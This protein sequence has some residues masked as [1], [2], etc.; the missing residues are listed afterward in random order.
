MLFRKGYLRVVIAT[1]TLALGINMPC[2]TV[3][4]SGDSVFLTALNYR[5]AAGRA[6]RRGF[7]LLGNVVFQGV[8]YDKV[9]RLLS[10]R[11]PD[12]NGHFPVTTT[13]VLRLF[14]LLHES[15]SPPY[16]IRA[17]DSLLSQPRLYL[18]GPS[19]RDQVLHHLRFSIEYLR[20]QRLLSAGGAPINFAGLVSHLYF[21]ENSSFALNVLLEGGYFHE[22]CSDIKSKE[23]S[24]LDTLMIVM[25]HLFGRRPC[26]QADQEFVEKIIHRS[27][28][29]VF[30][31]PLPPK[32][33][34]VLREHNKSTLQIFTTYVKTFVDQHILTED[35]TLPLTDFKAG[36][37]ETFEGS[38]E[39]LP[40]TRVRSSFA[41]LSGHGDTFD[42]ISDLCSTSREGVF[43]EEEVIPHLDVY[44]DEAK[45]PLNAY[46]YDFYK[47][48]DL[49]SLVKA[50]GI[51]RGDV[52]FTLNDFSLVLATIT[53]SLANFLKLPNSELDMIDLV[54]G[55]DTMEMVQ[56]DKF[57]EDVSTDDGKSSQA[58][59]VNE[60]KISTKPKG[61][62]KIV[63]SWDDAGD[64]A[65]EEGNDDNDSETTY[66]EDEYSNDGNL[67]NVYQALQKL[68]REFDT[69][70]KAIFA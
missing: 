35:N 45:A 30:L 2:A 43:L 3:V 68:K 62:S 46:L 7:D 59:L 17:I 11:L 50:N 1:G 15:G 18:D 39:S 24:T 67:L 29:I 5:Q 52:W 25:A 48:G 69:K 38:F 32:A 56:D 28:S 22:L 19:F 13:L 58:T 41:A 53:T 37:Q 40:P 10:S 20:R 26:R 4:F 16:A 49:N 31:P 70:F 36:G 12:L 42:S 57:A 63:D 66:A 60:T 65:A 54:G 51:R 61:K 44:P 55:G 27:S 34:R 14:T 9:C 47:N 8:S 21:T 6:G 33:A 23:S 64:D